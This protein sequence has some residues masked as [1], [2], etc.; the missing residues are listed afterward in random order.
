MTNYFIFLLIYKKSLKDWLRLCEC[1]IK[2]LLV[3]MII[4]PVHMGPEAIHSFCNSDL[5]EEGRELIPLSLHN[6]S[7]K[8]NCS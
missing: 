6:N 3:D 8:F 1:V 5:R 2:E 7:L 4:P